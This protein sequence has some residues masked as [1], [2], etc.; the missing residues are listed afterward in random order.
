MSP[1]RNVKMYL[2]SMQTTIPS[3]WSRQQTTVRVEA[4][5]QEDLGTVERI[6]QSLPIHHHDHLME[7]LR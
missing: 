4:L 2:N 1:K 3:P 6:L 5:V 7:Q